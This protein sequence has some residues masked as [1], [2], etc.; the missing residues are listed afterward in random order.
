MAKPI[1]L[2]DIV[3]T[4]PNESVIVSEEERGQIMLAVAREQQRI[5][6]EERRNRRPL[7]EH[8]PVIR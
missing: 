2:S 1:R 5:D 8:N 3:D 7:S 4:K 6:D